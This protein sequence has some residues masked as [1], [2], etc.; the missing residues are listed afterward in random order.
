[1]KRGGGTFRGED[2]DEDQPVANLRS[3]FDAEWVA[4]QTESSAHVVAHLVG[5]G[6]GP[7]T[8]PGILRPVC[9]GTRVLS[10]LRDGGPD[11]GLA[12]RMV[13]KVRELQWIDLGDLHEAAEMIMKRESG[14]DVSF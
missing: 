7:V 14:K 2:E 11:E 6:Q 4:K 3:D 13:E 1:A 8:I 12:G 9:I 10:E 5:E